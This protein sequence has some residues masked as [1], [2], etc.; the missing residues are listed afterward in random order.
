[1]Q[2]SHSQS[3]PEPACGTIEPEDGGLHVQLSGSQTPSLTPNERPPRLLWI[4]PSK[5]RKTPSGELKTRPFPPWSRNLATL[6]ASLAASTCAPTIQE[7]ASKG[8]PSPAPDLTALSPSESADPDLPRIEDLEVPKPLPWPPGLPDPVSNPDGSVSLPPEL[9]AATAHRL[10]H[11]VTMP[12]LCR[13]SLRGA[14]WVARQQVEKAWRVCRAEEA[15][16][17]AEIEARQAEAWSPIQRI[18]A[19]AAG[20][21]G[22]TGIGILLGAILV[23]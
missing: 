5:V 13:Q 20:V 1:M 11:Y 8:A 17:I 21:A 6:L 12:G 4:M 16:K 19:I 22:G 15:V 10:E 9:A 2:S 3:S 7:M 18:L 23:Q 14:A